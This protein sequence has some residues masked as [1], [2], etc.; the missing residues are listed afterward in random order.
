MAHAQGAL[1]GYVHPFDALPAPEDRSVALTDDLP[2]SA[3][4]GL[5]DYMEV[6]GFSDHRSTAAIWYRLLNCGFRIPAGAGTDA[7]ANFAS[8]RGP[9][10]LNRVFVQ[11]GTDATHEGWL[12][13]IRDGRTFATNGPLVQF[14]LDGRGPGSEIRLPRG[15]HELKMR[16]AVASIVPIDH[17]EVVANGD[18]IAGFPLAGDRTAAKIEQTIAVTRSGWYTLRASA[19]RAVHP[20]LDI[21]PFATTSPVYVIV[22]DEA[23]RSAADAR[24]FL[25]W[26]DRIEAFV[27]AHT[28]WNGPAERESVLGSLA[29]ARAVYQERTQPR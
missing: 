25:A 14:S 5:V 19:D 29:R 4:L 18:V 8:L 20:V 2:V 11:T 24:F 12:K 13:G 17:L 7:M 9:V 1:A 21:Y 3:A 10:G 23:I 26:L 15:A 16:A 6:V 28:D 22:G 27:R